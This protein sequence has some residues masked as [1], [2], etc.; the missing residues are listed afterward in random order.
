MVCACVSKP[1]CTLHTHGYGTCVHRGGSCNEGV[2]T[3]PECS[4]GQRRGFRDSGR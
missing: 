2:E 1:M 3:S 4:P